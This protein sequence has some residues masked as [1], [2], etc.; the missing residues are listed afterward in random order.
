MQ[1]LL[2]GRGVEGS[3]KQRCEVGLEIGCSMSGDRRVALGE[4]A[5]LWG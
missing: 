1:H 2:L 4:P 5:H 3:G